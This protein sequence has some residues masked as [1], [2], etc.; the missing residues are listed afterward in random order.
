MFLHLHKPLR[1]RA[2]ID[3]GKDFLLGNNDLDIVLRGF[4]YVYEAFYKAQSIPEPLC[5]RKIGL[6]LS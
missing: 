2:I 5:C 6:N 1:L 3:L 4:I